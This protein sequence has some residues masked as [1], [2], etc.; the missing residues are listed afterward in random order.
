MEVA[1]LGV[2]LELQLRP[3]PQPQAHQIRATNCDLCHSVR[4]HQVL[5]PLSEA[6]NPTCSLTETMLALL[7]C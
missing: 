7:T 6:R 1:G 3:M 4:Q 2:K 5:N